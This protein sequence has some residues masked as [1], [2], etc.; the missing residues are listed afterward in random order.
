MMNDSTTEIDLDGVIDRLLEGEL[1]TTLTICCG[2]REKTLEEQRYSPSLYSQ[3][4]L[5]LVVLP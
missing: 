1:A 4:L 2:T 3:L 5:L